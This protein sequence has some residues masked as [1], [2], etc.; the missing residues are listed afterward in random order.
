MKIITLT[1]NPAFDIHCYTEHFE[2]YHENLAEITAREAGG[3]GVNISRALTVN[4]VEN[5]AVLVLGEENA[6]SFRSGIEADGLKYLEITLPGRIRENITLHTENADETRISFR[7]FR[8]EDTLADRIYDVVSGTV[9][10]R[11]IVTLTGSLPSGIEMGAV[12]NL[13]ARLTLRG[14][15]IVIDS[16]SFGIDDLIETRPWL[17]KP[18]QEEISC[19]LGYPVNGFEDVAEAAEGLH[20]KGIENVMVSLGAQG[21]LLACREGTFVAIPPKIDALSTVGAGDSSIAGFIAAATEGKSPAE[22][23]RTAVAYGSAAC[24]REGTRPPIAADV[25]KIYGAVEVKK[26]R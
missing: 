3:K 21:A 6:A 24:L 10:E 1:L 5:L 13:L 20:E 19:Y 17:I 12:K 26:M 22:M 4:G 23:L 2:P 14:A 15:R 9:E 11:S 7:G 18:N 25:E 8:A 16:R